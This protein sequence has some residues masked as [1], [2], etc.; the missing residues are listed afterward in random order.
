MELGEDGRRT[1]REN[2]TGRRRDLPVITHAY[3]AYHGSAA[4]CP[5][6]LIIVPSS[7]PPPPS[8]FRIPPKLL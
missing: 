4:G 7:P 8:V 1:R 2:V 6:N 5:A 3:Q